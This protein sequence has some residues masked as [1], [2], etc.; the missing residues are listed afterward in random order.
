MKNLTKIFMAVA[1][2]L[3][4]FSCVQDTT[5]DLGVNI[6]GQGIKELTLSLEESRTHLGEKAEG[7]YP[8]YWSEGDKISVNGVVS[9]EAVIGENPAT[10]T[11]A[12]E[13]VAD[14][15]CVVYPAAQG[16]GEGTTYPVAFAATQPYTEGSFASGTAPMYGYAA[17][18]TAP[19]ELKHLA[20]AL[21]L[22]VKGN[23]E[24]ITSVVAMS[25]SG[26]LAGS[27]TVDCAT[28]ALTAVEATNT[29]AV[30]F[31][32]PLVLGAEAKH[33]YFA[34]PAGKYGIFSITLHTETDKM[35]VKFDSEAKPINAGAVREFAEFAYAANTNDA[36]DVFEIDSKDALIEFA[37]IAGTFYP[38]T[39]AVV[40]ADI[41]MTGY[42]WTPIEGF[43]AFEF[44]G[45]SNEGCEIKGLN[46]PLFGTTAATIKNVKL[47]DVAITLENPSGSKGSLVCVMEG[48]SI[49]NCE[50]AGTFSVSNP[51][52]EE[53]SYGGVVGIV[54]KAATISH[55]VNRC[56]V[57]VDISNN[58][59]VFIGGVLGRADQLLNI[60]YCDN[61]GALSL[62]GEDAA[63]IR[64][65]GVLGYISAGGTTA[66]Y[67]NNHAVLTINPKNSGGV[68][69]GGVFGSVLAKSSI[70]NSYNKQG[71]NLNVY[72]VPGAVSIG[73]IAG[74]GSSVFDIDTCENSGN[75][76]FSYQSAGQTMIGGIYGYN[77]TSSAN[78]IKNVT[79]HGS[80]TVEGSNTHHIR[81]G[82]V[83]GYSYT[84]TTLENL[85]NNGA[86][87][88]SASSKAGFCGGVIAY[89]E[90]NTGTNIINNST[91]TFSGTAT[92]EQLRFGGCISYAAGGSYKTMKNN[93]TATLTL[94]GT[95]AKSNILAGGVVGQNTSVIDGAENHATIS[96]GG[97]AGAMYYAGGVVGFSANTLTSL[98]NEG[99]VTFN[100]TAVQN[101]NVGGVVGK[102]ECTALTTLE[103]KAAITFAGQTTTGTKPE[104]SDD[105]CTSFGGVVGV[106]KGTA[107]ALC[108]VSGLTNSGVTTI[109][110]LNK[111]LKTGYSNSGG[112]IGYAI[113]CNLDNCDNTATEF[114]QETTATITKLEYKANAHG[115]YI[116]G[117]AGYCKEMGT[118]EN[119]DN[120]ATL[121]LNANNAIHHYIGGLFGLVET[122]STTSVE[123][124]NCSNSGNFAPGATFTTK[125][126]RLGGIAGTNTNVNYTQCSNSGIIS[127]TPSTLLTN[128]FYCGGLFG[129][130][131]GGGATSCINTGDITLGQN[132]TTSGATTYIGGLMGSNSGNCKDSHSL[133]NMTIDEAYVN[134]K[135]VIGGAVGTT[136]KPLDNVTVFCNI[137]AIGRSGKVGM[138]EGIAYAETSKASNCKV[139][140][141]L[142]WL[143]EERAD[144]E[145]GENTLVEEPG[146]LDASNWFKHIYSAEVT[147]AVAKGDGC[148]LLTAQ[149]TVQ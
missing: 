54:T 72:G 61:Y 103:N 46:A 26:K 15:L 111:G 124:S 98:T 117:V 62:T 101:H 8:L 65:G 59:H 23:G 84:N 74:Y 73:G 119:C 82:G 75:I 22:A 4:A 107:N 53:Y 1:V 51:A 45:G 90:L 131:S 64:I 27:F 33:I 5:E 134:T 11:F 77:N 114:K 43:G 83:I 14:K 146:N 17:D 7:L 91:V 3:F 102:A 60:T 108:E 149:P 16:V 96:F 67:L 63:D 19:I 41:D 29:V 141:K 71:A 6:K 132:T 125:R 122:S 97:S 79:N 144:E 116:G 135:A 21:R 126:F 148:E 81:T 118:I 89:A 130:L 100:G 86:I 57:S 94:S 121:N 110:A 140:G 38:R 69:F 104:Y 30:T 34:V 70:K 127:Y 78:T 123:V 42:D 39:K 143:S 136:S 18:A 113:H 68:H 31:A 24:A 13:V 10:A 2:A 147:E 20:G 120:S 58:K 55:V 106:I 133:C 115:I 87:N 80:I 99:S 28:G 52:N 12:V 35:T 92:S 112:V 56:T 25:E 50:V 47:T 142:I 88:V 139:G 66:E 93:S 128:Q 40:T 145:T 109:G 32:E 36:D 95:A 129:I 105:T 37:K 49:N 44:D 137:T 85:T 48:G 138:V 9:G 76:A